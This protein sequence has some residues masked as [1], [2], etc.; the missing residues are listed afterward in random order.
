MGKPTG[1]MDY[2]REVPKERAPLERINDWKEFKTKLPEENQKIQ[3]ARCMACGIP[4]C[5]SGILLKNMAS[6]C[7]VYNLIPEW[8]DLV[9]KGLWKEAIERL[10]RTNNFPEFT[11]RVCP[12]PCEGSCTVSINDPAVTIKTNEC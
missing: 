1:F 7:P 8:N 12:A 5:H 6:G 9:Y 2:L 3:G 4:F 11:G 10:H